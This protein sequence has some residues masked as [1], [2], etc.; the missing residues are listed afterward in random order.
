MAVSSIALIGMQWGDEGKGKLIDAL[1]PHADFVVRYQGGHNAGHTV[2]FYEDKKNETQKESV[3]HK[4]ILHLL[5]CGVAHS[6][7]QCVIANG[8]VI[9]LPALYEEIN[10]IQKMGYDILTRL[11]ISH[12]CS[13]ILP[14]HIALDKAVEGQK[15]KSYNIG[16]TCRGI[17]PAYEDHYAR[18]A[19]KLKDIESYDFEPRLK[20][21]LDYHSYL[22]GYYN[23][24]KK[25]DHTKIIAQIYEIYNEIK[26]TIVDTT[27]LLQNAVKNNRKII[28]EG[29]QGCGLD[30]HHGTYPFVTS[31]ATNIGGIFSGSGISHKNIQAVIGVVKGYA[32]RVG[33]GP[34]ATELKDHDG[35]KLQELGNEFGSTT[36]RPRRCGWLDLQYLKRA[37]QI[38]GVDGL[39]VTKL[40]VLGNF[41]EIKLYVGANERNKQIKAHSQLEYET[42]PGW[43]GNDISKIRD[44]TQLPDLLRSFI[45]RIETLTQVPVWGLSVGPS[46]E[47]LIIRQDKCPSLQ[48][49]VF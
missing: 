23:V 25:F 14:S 21:I 4:L 22:L 12:Y 13:L 2:I 38:N 15:E 36:G 16:T 10:K 17:G 41:D 11:S 43:M 37:V 42:M 19:I 31:S 44:Y 48:A 35:K 39:F 3:L 24:F 49:W 5:P 40:D 18:R 1:A 30:V 34:F 45:E 8:V 46:R 29:A 26:H 28:W 9:Y 47:Q 27:D 32:T 33:G 6:N 7:T 20:S